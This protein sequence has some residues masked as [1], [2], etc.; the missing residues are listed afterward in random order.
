MKSKRLKPLEKYKPK[1]TINPDPDKVL[2]FCKF[3]YGLPLAV[4]VLAL[5]IPFFRH[6]LTFS[7]VALAILL[8]VACGAAYDDRKHRVK[9][10]KQPVFKKPLPKWSM[11]AFFLFMILVTAGLRLGFY[12][13]PAAWL[14]SWIVTYSGIQHVKATYDPEEKSTNLP[15]GV[16]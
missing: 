3:F 2:L 6:I 1:V 5:F 14:V 12:I 11:T 16:F 10:G 9:R 4:T 15:P 7:S 13:V 8:C